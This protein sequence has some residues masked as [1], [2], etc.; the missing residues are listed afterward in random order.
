MPPYIK[1]KRDEAAATAAAAATA[2]AKVTVAYSDNSQYSNHAYTSITS[3]VSQTILQKAVQ[4]ND[5]K[6]R[7]CYDTAANRHV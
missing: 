4:N 6:Q 1:K 5:Y 2:K 7:Y 3:F